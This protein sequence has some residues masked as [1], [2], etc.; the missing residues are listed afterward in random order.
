ML[1]QKWDCYSLLLCYSFLPLSCKQDPVEH[2]NG[3][4]QT[5]GCLKRSLGPYAHLRKLDG[6]IWRSMDSLAG[7]VL[8][9]VS[10]LLSG[11]IWLYFFDIVFFF[12]L[13]SDSGLY[14]LVLVNKKQLWNRH[15]FSLIYNVPFN[16]CEDWNVMSL[17]HVLIFLEFLFCI[18]VP[19]LPQTLWGLI[20][21][22]YLKR[23]TYYGAF[24]FFLLFFTWDHSLF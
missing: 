14:F 4:S 6:E 15:C 24:F 9:G 18:I 11:K 1:R 21:S 23:F 19:V 16:I 5:S 3:K 13:N 22:L 2:A 10:L 12:F 7:L 20:S 17:W 8:Y